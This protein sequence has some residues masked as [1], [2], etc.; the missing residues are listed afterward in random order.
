MS[1][2]AKT[3]EGVAEGKALFIRQKPGPWGGWQRS[4]PCQGEALAGGWKPM[5]SRMRQGVETLP[6]DKAGQ[7]PQWAGPARHHAADLGSIMEIPE[8]RVKGF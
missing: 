4:E 3:A 5:P 7:K 2:A 6:G 1:R 8:K